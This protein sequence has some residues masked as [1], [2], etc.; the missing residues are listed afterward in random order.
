MALTQTEELVCVICLD[1]IDEDK[2]NDKAQVTKFKCKHML[3]QGCT[4][5][6]VL[7]LFHKHVDISCP[8]CRNVECTTTSS[9]YK[10]TKQQ[11]GIKSNMRHG[12]DIENPSDVAIHYEPLYIPLWKKV[13]LFGIGL[14]TLSIITFLILWIMV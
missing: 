14:M 13:M 4:Y 2:V 10:E 7:D 3:H 9:I 6:Y 8:I 5:K 12:V 1:P 11:L